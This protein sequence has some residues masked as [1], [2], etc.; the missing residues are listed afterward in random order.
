MK[1]IATALFTALLPLLQATAE[2]YTFTPEDYL[3]YGIYFSPRAEGQSIGAVKLLNIRFG[4]I[5]GYYAEYAPQVKE[6]PSRAQALR[7]VT[8]RGSVR[9]NRKD[10][11]GLTVTRD[12]YKVG[13]FL[14]TKRLEVRFEKAS[15]TDAQG[16]TSPCV[17]N[18]V[19]TADAPDKGIVRAARTLEI[20]TSTGL[21]FRYRAR[22]RDGSAQS[23]LTR[24]AVINN[25]AWEWRA[26]NK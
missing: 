26:G 3:E 25:Y 9:V 16:I 8:G 12:T 13:K 4:N 5:E 11:E 17:A 19:L 14:K 23:G 7:L 6:V 10:N 1:K 18:L 22:R 20:T 2:P 24:S 15:C 21:S